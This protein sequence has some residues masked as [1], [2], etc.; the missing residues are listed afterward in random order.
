MNVGS[1]VFNTAAF[2]L[3]PFT[4][5]FRQQTHKKKYVE[6]TRVLYPND[7]F[8]YIRFW[9]APFLE[10]ERI[11]PRHGKIIDLGCGEGIFANFL[12]ITS[13]QRQLF[14]VEIDKNRLK[15]ADRGL[16]NTN[17]SVGDITRKDIP[18]AD[19]IVLIHV[20]HHLNSFKQQEDLILKCRDKLKKG[21][22]L[23]IAEVEPKWSFKYL[24]AWLTDHYLVPWI[25]E[26]KFYSPIFFRKSFEWLALL[27][28]YGFESKA[29]PAE[30]GK[31]FPH[32][33]LDCTKE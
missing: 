10:L 5:N 11:V 3:K 15:K 26:K 17:F 24:L 31:P 29:I 1:L 12:A 33:I 18:I 22:R 27:Q 23:I 21:G 2:L 19:A 28:Q 32:V 9:D 8:F 20:L 14:G 7:R 4:D 16:A 30:I 13:R 6:Q 25:F